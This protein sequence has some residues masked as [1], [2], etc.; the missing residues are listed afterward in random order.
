[1]RY[2]I[3]ESSEKGEPL[4][5]SK[6]VRNDVWDVGKTLVPGITLKIVLSGGESE[7]NCIAWSPNGQL[8]AL[9]SGRTINIW[10]VE[11]DIILARLEGHK[12]IV[13]GI[14]WS[15]DGQTLAS[16]SYDRNIRI[17]DAN[18]WGFIETLTGHKR[19][20]TCIAWSHD[21]EKIAS[22]SS[23]NTIR[24]WNAKTRKTFAI[25][26]GHKD[27]INSVAWSSD[28]LLASCS[29]DRAMFIWRTD[30]MLVNKGYSISFKE[31]VMA[32]GSNWK[33][34]LR[35]ELNS[36][37]IVSVVWAPHQSVLAS[38]IGNNIQLLDVN[39]N[40]SKVLEGHTKLIQSLSFSSEGNLLASKSQDNTI[41]IW[42]TDTGECV[43]ML[44]DFSLIDKSILAF[45]TL[46]P[47]LA[48]SGINNAICILNLDK[49][50]LLGGKPSTEFVR[51]T[52]AKIVLV[53]ESNVGKSCLAMRL[54]EDRYPSESEQGTTHGIRFWPMRP[55]QLSQKAVALEG[56][57]RDIVLW[58]LGGQ[59]EYRLVHQLFLHD[60]T[61][62]LVLIDPTRGRT[63]FE[64]V[65][66]WTKRLE[67]QLHGRKATKLLIGS[68][69]D[70]PSKLIDRKS[71]DSLIQ[72]LG[73]TGYCEI[74][75]FKPR[76][77]PE[78]REAI[79]NA[80]D[81]NDLSKT[82]R[83]E[84]FQ[85]IRDE[86]EKCRKAGNVI[87]Y[88]KDLDREIRKQ[89]AK[90]YGVEAVETVAE[91]LAAQGVIALT[92]L[93]SGD[94]VLILQIGEI[95][96]YAG[97]LI[98]AAR[99]NPSGVPALEECN[100]TALDFLLPGILEKDR[101]RRDQE[102]VILE[103]VV[104]LLI[105]NGIC[106]RSHGLLVFPTLF[107]DIKADTSEKLMHS[108]SLFYDF[109]GAID[110][111]YAS[112]VAWLVIGRKFGSPRL[113]AN[114]VEFDE[115]DKGVCGIQQIKYSSGLS[116]LDLYFAEST[117]RERR[118]F[119][120]RFIEDHLSRQ[121]IE[122]RE[123]QAIKCGG[124]GYEI[125]ED[126]VHE[127]IAREKEDVICPKCR[128]LTLISEGVDSIR[129][130][131]P[132]SEQKII[133][134][135]KEIEKRTVQE[136]EKAKQAMAASINVSHTTEGPIRILHLS[137]LHFTN[138]TSPQSRLQWLID[139]IT[140]GEFLGF[141]SINY[142]VITGDITEK[143][144]VEGFEK[145]Q[146]F[147]RLL[148]EQFG[149]S[150]QRCIFVPGNHD[151]QD[152]R[153]SYEWTG[154]IEGLKPDQWV[155]KDDIYLVRNDDKYK[156]RLNKFSEAF[157]HKVV[158]QPY[159]LEYAL[160]G[161]S[162]L[163][164]DTQIQFIAFNS[165]WQIDQFNR[166]RSGI[167]PDSVACAIQ[168][169]DKQ[170]QTAIANS[171]LN[172]DADVL[173]IGLWHHAV[174]GQDMMTNTDF[175]GHLQ[176]N[177]VKL[178]LHGDVHEL[179]RDIIGYWHPKKV[180]IIGAGSFGSTSKGL[181]ESTARLYNL[182]EIQRDLTSVRVHTRCQTKPDGIWDGWYQWPS[183]DGQS[184]RLPYYDIK[185]K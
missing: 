12:G 124:C 81:W 68:K 13:A 35:G 32:I 113:W 10:D 3:D 136:V 152:L 16:G 96:R 102:R 185:L 181:P 65:E 174:T 119:F 180:N 165:C 132:K 177:E 72:N 179:R 93:A 103:S 67:K 148:T 171:R 47:R 141:E 36:S 182:L 159:P 145:A 46:L 146:E 170:K 80:L 90:T 6:Q 51:Y 153:E 127:N 61:L 77:I 101:L 58:D 92:H 60:T 129:R 116:H 19:E 50:I 125:S 176:K 111:I 43:A 73:F 142:L 49:E 39:T 74:S 11:H 17:W 139:D 162:Y 85:C 133:A 75:A 128:K 110:N 97:S 55:E 166:K 5:T 120:I 135:R 134:L 66:A 30:N 112:L 25:L 62:A 172:K 107:P 4:I 157:F 163:F 155:K 23:D 2:I 178:C 130:R 151:L 9:A 31:N 54:A 154:E 82:S 126:I 34:L 8:L 131:D 99:E 21:G 143:G 137:D 84:L 33:N 87:L 76:G 28:G 95:E 27:R 7:I 38:I 123:H 169:A 184:G 183:P 83:P 138:D 156:L 86:I 161:I 168:N 88:L 53:G 105:Q 122:V 42:S 79:A 175:I 167:H 29:S 121:G 69:M 149:L 63:A 56:E 48:T 98:V 114:R 140:K 115:P 20:I 57:R 89:F 109:T 117:K 71:L 59:D 1:M 24:I 106:F 40:Q 18:G 22:G 94:K 100:L 41:R 104:E 44:N 70:E 78:L 37:P 91:Q 14:T 45:H 150:A 108:V 164:S 160:Q 144:K 15:P 173:R 147:I 26:K 158:L 64:E 118:N 52:S